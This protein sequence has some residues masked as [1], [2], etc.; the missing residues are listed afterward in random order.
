MPKPK[1]SLP[2]IK[3][4]LKDLRKLFTLNIGTVMFG[5]LLVYLLVIGMRYLTDSHFDSY[6]VVSGPLSGNE[7][8]TGLAIREEEV[9][10]ADSSGYVTYY[11]REGNKINAN[12]TVFGLSAT[13]T[14]NGTGRISQEDL[15]KIRVQM[16]NFSSGFDPSNFNS[17]YSFKY[18]LA[19]TILNYAGAQNSGDT[20]DGET[21]GDEEDTEDTSGTS[22]TSTSGQTLSQTTTDGIVLYSMDGYENKKMEDLKTEDFDQNSYEKKDLKTTK[23]VQAGDPIYTLITDERW[24]LLIPLSDKQ[25]AQL[26][27]ND[28]IRVKFNKDGMTQLGSF[29]IE[30]IDGKKYGRIYFN[31][32]LIRYAS[33]RFL[34]IE[35]VTNTQ[36]G[37]KIPLTAITT[38]DFY[39]V[40]KEFAEVDED[41]N[42]QGFNLA[43][44]DKN[45]ESSTGFVSPTIY[46][47]TDDYY[48]FEK[49]DKKKG[50]SSENV[51]QEGDAI[52]KPDSSDRYVVGD[53]GA[54]EGVYCINQG[55]AVFRRIE[56]IDQNEEYAIVSKDTTYGLSRYDHIAENADSVKESDIVY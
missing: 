39:I 37:L 51:L 40:P 13:K 46:A 8:Y 50:G 41:G 44:T 56:L 45:G 43:T 1:K 53:T 18:E 33:D 32:G 9:V 27:D 20:E 17:T 6:Q 35:L 15:A 11:A 3:I 55:Y 47:A 49:G 14:K 23:Q 30:K 10:K 19:G 5:V 28:S 48:Y 52:Q 22:E 4:S 38:K 24:S 25:A 42:Y 16:S 34:D 36:T 26:T 7:L 29:S 12:G 2:K 54:L 31:K 21:T